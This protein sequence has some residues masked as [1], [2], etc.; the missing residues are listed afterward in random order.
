MMGGY[1]AVTVGQAEPFFRIG[2]GI[3]PGA[4][5]EPRKPGHA[6]IEPLVLP[7]CIACGVKYQVFDPTLGVIPDVA[8]NE[9]TGEQIVYR[10]LA[11]IPAPVGAA[12]PR[13]QTQYNPDRYRVR[14][15]GTFLR[16]MYD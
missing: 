12:V 1:P 9:W 7:A 3:G 16:V 14:G 11:T 2:V 4:V 13:E 6:L 10:Q 5:V 15:G 8:L